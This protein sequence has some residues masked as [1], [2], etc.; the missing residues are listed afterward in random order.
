MKKVT[1]FVLFCAISLPIFSQS[2][3]YEDLAILF[4]KD[5]NTGTARYNAMSGAFGA[6]GGDVSAIKI[7]PASGA[8]FNNSLFSASVDSRTAEINTKYYGNTT[9]TQNDYFNFSQAGVVFVY[10]NSTNSDLTLILLQTE[11][12]VLQLSQNFL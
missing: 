1:L 2:L 12:V 4:S 6:L 7:N 11:T 8:I 9:T 5:N 3:G 10:T